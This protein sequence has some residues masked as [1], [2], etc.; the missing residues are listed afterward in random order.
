[1]FKFGRK[2]PA[3]TAPEPAPV[4]GWMPQPIESLSEPLRTLVERPVKPLPMGA[5][6]MNGP[7]MGGNWN[8]QDLHPDDRRAVYAEDRAAGRL[9]W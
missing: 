6:G 3:P 1:M 7:A 2:T 4:R 9:G 5:P 8:V